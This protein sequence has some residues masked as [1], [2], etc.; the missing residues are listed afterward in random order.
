M[1]SKAMAG[2]V[3]SLRDRRIITGLPTDKEPVFKPSRLRRFFINLGVL[4]MSPTTKRAPT[5]YNNDLNWQKIASVVA[6][7]GAILAGYWATWQR[8]E[9]AGDAR[10]YQR[11]QMEETEEKIRNLERELGI[12][13][14]LEE[15][16]K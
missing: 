1:Q 16:D 14:K 3:L 8:A 6:I 5:R 9:S 4:P 13:K 7:V 15:A 12:K 10:G 11:R 2:D